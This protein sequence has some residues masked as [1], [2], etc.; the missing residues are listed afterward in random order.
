MRRPA[1]TSS[2]VSCA[3]RCTSYGTLPPSSTIAI[4]E[5]RLGA[6]PRR[7]EARGK[8]RGELAGVDLFQPHHRPGLV[9]GPL[10]GEH[11]LHQRRLG[12]G[13]DISDVALLLHCRP[14]RMLDA[15][16]VEGRHR[17]EFVER[18]G[19][20]PLAGARDPG[21]KCKHLC[22]EAGRVGRSAD[23]RKG[24]AETGGALVRGIEAELGP[25]P[26]QQIG[27]PPPQ[28]A[29]RRVGGK[30]RAGV[31]LEEADVGARGGDRQ[32]DGQHPPGRQ[33]AQHVA[34]ERRLAVAARRN[35]KDLLPRRQVARQ[36][37]PLGR[38]VGERR[39]GHDLAVDEGIVLAHYVVSR[40]HYVE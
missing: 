15:A 9:E 18:D 22:G 35:E 23:G 1:L 4:G 6:E 31:G 16:A 21:G 26:L 39:G 8:E 28:P 24:N 38:P 14:Q 33:P 20:A 27:G 11:P 17:L 32:L 36:P 10:R 25:H 34:D 3:S 12:P 19:H 37:L 30:Q 2:Q 7:A 5:P 29:D 40:S 13:K